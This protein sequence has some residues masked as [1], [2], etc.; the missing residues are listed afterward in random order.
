M[1]AEIMTSE[2]LR[3]VSQCFAAGTSTEEVTEIA[4]LLQHPKYPPSK[5]NDH[6]SGVPAQTPAVLSFALECVRMLP[7]RRAKDAEWIGLRQNRS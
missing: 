2:I 5:R 6:T 4:A 1:G 3:S 7:S